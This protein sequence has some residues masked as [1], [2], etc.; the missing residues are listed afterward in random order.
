[1]TLSFRAASDASACSARSSHD[2]DILVVGESPSLAAKEI[3]KNG[4][5]PLHATPGDDFWS[6]YRIVSLSK[7]E[8]RELVL[9]STWT[10]KSRLFSIFALE[11]YSRLPGS[12]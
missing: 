3:Q 8:S 11:L 12:S 6:I 4:L 1:M 9:R 2:A 7:G 5:G 10:L